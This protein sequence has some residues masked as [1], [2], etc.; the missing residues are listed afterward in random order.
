MSGLFNRKTNTVNPFTSE[1]QEGVIDPLMS[2]IMGM[3]FDQGGLDAAFGDTNQLNQ[4]GIGALLGLNPESILQGFQGNMGMA[5]G[6]FGDAAGLATSDPLGAQGFFNTVLDPSF[7]DVTNDP[8]VQ[9]VLDSINQQ[10]QT[11]FNVGADKI[12]SSAA[13]AQGGL[14]AGTASTN[15]LSRLSQNIGQDV[16]NQS[17]NVLLSEQAR[18]QGIQ[19]AAAQ[20][21]LGFG[22]NQAG[23]LGNLGNLMGNQS[24]AQGQ[25]GADVASGLQQNA[26]QQQLFPLQQQMALAQLLKSGQAVTQPSMFDNLTSAA[27]SAGGLMAGIG[28]MSD[29]RAKDNIEIADKDMDEFLD[30]FNNYS[31]TYK[32]DTEKDKWYGV[33]AQDLEKSEV[34]RSMVFEDNGLKMINV[35]K[36][37]SVLLASQSRINKKL[38]KIVEERNGK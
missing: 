32:H 11:G 8:Q 16:A 34:G 24:L 4:Q 19:Q 28:M 5:Q 3:Q 7:T 27:G 18:R 9:G 31:F 22:L 23:M 30:S 36:A 12:A 2:T 37:V 13:Q 21:G 29:A 10:A 25:F 15:Q 17:A 14:G 1:A 6:L 26:L 33:M 38:N 20:Q 35:L